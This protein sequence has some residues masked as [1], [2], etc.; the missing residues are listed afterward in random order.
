M[1]TVSPV[2]W[3]TRM[4]FP[5][6]MADGD[7]TIT[8]TAVDYAGNRTAATAD[9]VVDRTGVASPPAPATSTVTAARS[10]G[11]FISGPTK[12]RWAAVTA[13]AADITG[14]DVA[15]DGTVVRRASAAATSADL[16]ALSDGPRTVTS[17]RS[18]RRRPRQRQRGD[19]GT[20]RRGGADDHRAHGEPAPGARPGPAYRSR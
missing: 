4:P 11:R 7:H 3:S 16:P 15:V 1:A 10:Y 20:G 12:A 2:T 9:V 6:G 17:R 8:I 14:Y 5:V 18:Q 19:H 13:S